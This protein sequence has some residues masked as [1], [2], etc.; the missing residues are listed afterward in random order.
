MNTIEQ[1]SLQIIAGPCAAESREQ[2]LQTAQEAMKRGIGT[3]R[4]SLWKPRTAPGWSGIWEKGIPVF[5]EIADMGVR[6]ATEVLLP[7]HVEHILNGTIAKNRDAR[8]LLWLGSRNQNDILQRD[9]GSIIA[10]EPRVQLM[11]KNQMWKDRKHWEGIID[12]VVS[13]GAS[14]LQLLLCHRGFA[15]GS[16]TLRNIPDM[17][18]ALRVKDSLSRKH[19]VPMPLILDGSHIAGMSAENVMRTTE[20]LSQKTLTIDG[21]TLKIDGLM[22][23]THPDPDRAQTDKNQQLTWGQLD[24]LRA[25]L[26]RRGMV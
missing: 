6:P 5:L 14:P 20:R 23:E 4:M 19:N 3:V 7:R 11:V 10:G 18:M 16:K 24:T 8:V 9:I 1:K 12:H 22:L 21:R 26:A 2:M 13:G 25:R 17:D 15:P